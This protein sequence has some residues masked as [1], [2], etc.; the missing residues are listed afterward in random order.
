[1]NADFPMIFVC[2][3]QLCRLHEDQRRELEHYHTL[4]TI[5][6]YNEHYYPCF[7]V[8]MLYL[9]MSDSVTSK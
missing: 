2:R 1:M 5:Y 8:L 3:I 4:R 9:P 6:V 7:V